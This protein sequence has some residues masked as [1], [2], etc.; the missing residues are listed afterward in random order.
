[1]LCWGVLLGSGEGAGE[2]R[3]GGAQ[4]SSVEE[5][6]FD[7][8]VKGERSAFWKWKE[9][10]SRWLE[11]SLQ[12]LAGGRG[13]AGGQYIQGPLRNKGQVGVKK[14]CRLVRPSVCSARSTRD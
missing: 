10:H 9:R 6:A 4:G 14:E 12:R 11:Q 1:M 2:E 8:N 3:G 5:V 13:Q 7:Q